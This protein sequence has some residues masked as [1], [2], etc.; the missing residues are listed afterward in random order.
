MN[1][2]DVPA[3]PPSAPAGGRQPRP[4]GSGSTSEEV[5][6]FEG[7][8]ERTGVVVELKG[9]RGRPNVCTTVSDLIRKHRRMGDGLFYLYSGQWPEGEKTI[10]LI[11]PTELPSTAAQQGNP[12]SNES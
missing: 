4:H 2:P 12:P 11:K 6:V 10:L 8:G 7:I 3:P 5:E 9:I 1:R